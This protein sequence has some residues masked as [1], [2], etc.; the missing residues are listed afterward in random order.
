MPDRYLTVIFGLVYPAV[1]VSLGALVVYV[2]RELGADGDGDGA[3]P[4]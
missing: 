2:Q 3:A 1:L 4:E